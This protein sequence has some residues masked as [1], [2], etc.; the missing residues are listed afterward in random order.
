MTQNGSKKRRSVEIYF[1]L[2]LAA[3]I[4]LIPQKDDKK[5]SQIDGKGDTGYGFILKADKAILNCIF[6]VDS[7]GITAASMD[8]T[9]RIYY[10]G[11]V[12][13]VNFSFEIID[14]NYRQKIVVNKTENP[15]RFFKVEELPH[16][17][18]AVFHWQPPLK[19]LSDNTYLVNVKA[20]GKKNVNGKDEQVVTATTQFSL[21][22]TFTSG[23]S[24]GVFVDTI[25]SPILQL[26]S[27]QNNLN[28][29]MSTAP[30][31]SNFFIR[32][33]D[34]AINKIAHDKWQNIV[35]IVGLNSRNDFKEQPVLTVVHMMDKCGGTANINSINE[36]TVEIVGEAPDCGRMKIKLSIKRVDGLTAETEFQVSAQVKGDP[37]YDKVMYPGITYKIDPK[38]PF[39]TGQ[40]TQAKVV[41][42]DGKYSYASS[43]GDPFTF[44]PSINDTGKILNLERYIDGKIY[45]Q[46]YQ[47]N[48][49]NFP[50]PEIVDSKIISGNVR[51]MT[52]SY[53]VY[54]N[55]ENMIESI[56]FVGESNAYAQIIAGKT[57]TDNDKLT[58]YQEFEIIPKN[59]SKPYQFKLRLVSENGQ[60]SQVF[61]YPPQR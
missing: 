22:I 6:R 16:E 38:L 25:V 21:N 27:E 10:I 17:N 47:I 42:K 14:Q 28:P 49:K 5:G 9:N 61:T 41:S 3:L 19:D 20:T 23:G 12:S 18:C 34:N 2:Y 45:D 4:L 57:R 40:E 31:T 54:N 50:P 33:R 11:D 55:H 39:L 30:L 56:E 58:Y 26:P 36:K 51:I 53:G 43:F 8:T 15:S 24:S 13:D 44:T 1:I 46:V 37:V 35:Y 7:N 29:S 60:K 59:P 32:A 52:Q 48:I